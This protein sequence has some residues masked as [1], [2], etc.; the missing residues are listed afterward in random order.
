MRAEVFNMHIAVVALGAFG[1]VNPTLSFVTE[2][3]RREIV[4][5]ILQQKTSDRS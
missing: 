3:I 4:L 5:H 2:L 1:H